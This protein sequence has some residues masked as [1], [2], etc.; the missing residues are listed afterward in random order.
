[1]SVKFESE[2]AEEAVPV[3]RA[4]CYDPPRPTLN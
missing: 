2:T 4:L 3:T 1:M